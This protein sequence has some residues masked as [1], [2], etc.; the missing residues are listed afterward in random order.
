MDPPGSRLGPWARVAWFSLNIPPP[1]IRIICTGLQFADH[2]R[3]LTMTL[4]LGALLVGLAATR[5]TRCEATVPLTR[6]IPH[7]HPVLRSRVW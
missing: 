1:L 5:P 6:D 4:L 7:D 3:M 2:G